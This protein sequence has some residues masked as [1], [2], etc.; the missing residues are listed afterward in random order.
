MRH[1]M[2]WPLKW[3]SLCEMLQRFAHRDHDLLAHEVDAGDFFGDR[4]LDLDA[5]VHFQEIEIAVVV[6]DEFDRAGVGV[7]GDFG[8]AHG[9]FAHFFAQIFEFVFDQR[10]RGFFDHLLVA[11][12][13]GAIAFAE[14]D[15]VAV[16]YRR[17]SEIRCGAGSR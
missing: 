3:M 7:M 1:S 11:A 14:V 10:R 8:D 16:V 4:M 2:A 5:L 6:D 17:G 15:D 13:N 12:L 9:G